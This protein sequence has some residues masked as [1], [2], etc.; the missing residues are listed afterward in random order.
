S[1][2]G[3]ATEVVGG[4]VAERRLA[5]RMEAAGGGRGRPARQLTAHPEGR[6]VLASVISHESWRVGA[7]ELCGASV[8]GRAGRHRGDPPDAVLAQLRRAVDELRGRFGSRVRGLG[9][10][11]PG[12]VLD[13]RYL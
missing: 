9:V 2:T 1:G 10:G 5:E 12:I 13:E 6:L 7:V 4:L 3:G 8:A 11:G